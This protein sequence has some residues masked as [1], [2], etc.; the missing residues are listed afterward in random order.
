MHGFD[1]EAYFLQT[2]AYALQQHGC[3]DL[4]LLT[5]D[6]AQDPCHESYERLCKYLMAYETRCLCL[7]GNHDDFDLMLEHL[8]KGLVSCDKQLVLG[9]WQFIGLNS[10]IPGKSGG[11]LS[12][13]ELFFLETALQ[14]RPDLL[15]L[16]AVHHHCLPTGSNWMDRMQIENSQV[17]LALLEP[18]PQ[19]KAVVSGH[20]HQEL[21]KQHKNVV[22]LTTPATCFQFTPFSNSFS[23]DVAPPGYRV[24]NLL[25]D[26]G[27]T[28]TCY[29]LPT[30]P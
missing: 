4:I 29:W 11:R 7:P 8:N 17:F 9:N 20:V 16:I 26:G 28:S 14:N 1:T 10:Q 13:E 19:V 15:T 18:Y 23:I 6:L 22:I 27:I 21:S 25:P 2:V 12:V 3:F 30:K 24:L 5:G